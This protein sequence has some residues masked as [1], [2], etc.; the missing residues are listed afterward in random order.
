MPA[1]TEAYVEQALIPAVNRLGMGPVGAFRLEYGPETPV[2]FV[3]IA[4]RS[5]E[6]LVTLDTQLAADPVFLK[7][8]DPFW[9]APAKSPAFIRVESR[10]LRALEGWPALVVPPGSATAGKRIV[11]LRTYESPSYAAHV[12][13]VEMFAQGEFGIFRE[14][15]C[16]P[17]FFADTLIGPRMPSLTYMLSFADMAALEAGWAA[18]GNNPAWKRLASSPRYNYES[19]VS[20]VSNLILSPISASQI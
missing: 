11:Q 8:A 16:N 3:L 15:D 12:R 5:V 19:I 14:S 13:K 7:A 18:F 6:S 4:G 20:N 9:N 17:V 10:L 2:L 1:L